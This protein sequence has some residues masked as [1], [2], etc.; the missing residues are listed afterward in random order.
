MVEKARYHV[1]DLRPS[2]HLSQYAGRLSVRWANPRSCYRDL[3]RTRFPVVEIRPAAWA[4][5][6]PGHVAF[7]ALVSEV[8]RLPETWRAV[9]AATRGVY[10]L[11]DP[12]DGE[13]YVGSATGGDGLLGR[14]LEYARA[15]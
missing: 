12:E 14:W 4:E 5:P 3:A 6:F 2:R 10:V 11:V 8:E 9:L 15:G 1:Y 7:S 13:L